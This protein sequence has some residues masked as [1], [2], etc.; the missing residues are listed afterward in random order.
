MVDAI[1]VRQRPW[2]TVLLLCGKCAR[3]LD[4]GYGPKG[5]DTLRDALR[6]E[7][8]DRGLRRQ[9]Q[10]IETRCM[11]VCPKKAIT[12][13]NASEPGTIL[14]VPRKTPPNE[15]L[16]LLLGRNCGSAPELE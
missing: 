9:I 1:Q 5:R 2:K 4:G 8:S 11:S 15:A 7:L 16:A 10:I 13:L 3:K 6:A 12:A 14:F